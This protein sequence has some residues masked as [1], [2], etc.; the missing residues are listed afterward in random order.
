MKSHAQIPSFTL[1]GENRGFPDVV[2]CEDIHARAHLHDWIIAPHRH[3]QMVQIFQIETGAA[4]TQ[5]DSAIGLLKPKEFLYIPTN[6][7]HGFE[8]D[9]GTKGRVISLPSPI[10]TSF[11]TKIPQDLTKPIKG[12]IDDTFGFLTQQLAQ[13]YQSNGTYRTERLIGLSHVILSYVAERGARNASNTPQSHQVM[14]RF[15]ALISETLNEAWRPGDYANAL[16]MTP[17]HLGR[18]CRDATG[19]STSAYIDTAVMTEASR[20]LAFTRLS[21]SEIGYRLGY[22]DPPYFSRRFHK[23]CG[24]T[25]SA[26]RA[27]FITSKP[28]PT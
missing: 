16:A 3:G 4:Q 26:Y 10:L 14:D 20:L 1:F 5:I 2:H 6:V 19:K 17:G 25:P 12:V 11:A 28:D 23:I 27:Q 7:V 9:K 18:I 8:F 13:S 24:M 15:D 22:S 21:V